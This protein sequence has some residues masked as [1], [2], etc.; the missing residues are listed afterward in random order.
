MPLACA[1]SRARCGLLSALARI[2]T[3]EMD[4]L[5]T[6][7]I[8]GV[9][10][11]LLLMWWVLRRRRFERRSED[12]QKKTGKAE[13]ASLHPIINTRCI[14]CGSC[15]KACPEQEHHEILGILGGRAALINP[16]DCIGHGA[17]RSPASHRSACPSA[18]KA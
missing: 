13:P 2:T 14:G 16:G 8:Y 7:L 4:S 15:V 12:V 11:A 10:L 5:T 17:C 18:G 9:P 6:Y 1:R 3:A